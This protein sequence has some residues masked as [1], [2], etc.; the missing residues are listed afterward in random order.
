MRKKGEQEIEL[1]VVGGDGASGGVLVMEENIWL[2][3]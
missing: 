3:I 1:C 2:E